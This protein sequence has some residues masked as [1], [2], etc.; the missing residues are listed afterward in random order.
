MLVNTHL[1]PDEVAYIVEDSQAKVLVDDLDLVDA[2]IE[3]G[4]G[5]DRRARSVW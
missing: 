4:A 2:L 5:R 3:A 1:K